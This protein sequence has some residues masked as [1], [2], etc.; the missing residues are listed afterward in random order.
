MKEENKPSQ[1]D[2]EM[3][4][5]EFYKDPEVI[6][7][8]DKILE[9][10]IKS[11]VRNYLKDEYMNDWELSVKEEEDKMINNLKHELFLLQQK[12]LPRHTL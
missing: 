9:I 3:T 11:P 1:K 5:V 2:I 4:A 7:I 6:S 8:M 10:R 12:Y